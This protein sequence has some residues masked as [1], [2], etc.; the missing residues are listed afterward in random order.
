MWGLASSMLYERSVRNGHVESDQQRSAQ[1]WRGSVPLS[2]FPRPPSV[3]PRDAFPDPRKLQ[4]CRPSALEPPRLLMIPGVLLTHVSQGA[5]WIAAALHGTALL[6]NPTLMVLLGPIEIACRLQGGE[7]E[8]IREGRVVR[9]QQ[10]AHVV[11]DRL[12]ATVVIKDGTPVL[13]ARKGHRHWRVLLPEHP[14]H[15]L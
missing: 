1:A 4:P 8:R 14:Q 9:L 10:D 6:G 3:H 13:R 15:L 5:E 12:L 11:G 2:G 7:V